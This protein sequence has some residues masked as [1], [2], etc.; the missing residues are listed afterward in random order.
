MELDT[1]G[2][3]TDPFSEVDV[4]NGVYRS[5]HVTCLFSLSTRLYVNGITGR[6]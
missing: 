2:K 1:D 6:R 3:S 4:S 5:R